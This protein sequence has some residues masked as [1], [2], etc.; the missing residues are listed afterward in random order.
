MT[1][2]RG[3]PRTSALIADADRADA[4]P[5]LWRDGASRTRAPQPVLIAAPHH[6]RNAL[7]HFSTQVQCGR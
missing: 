7:A 1:A 6:S 4:F 2:A 5:A 3:V